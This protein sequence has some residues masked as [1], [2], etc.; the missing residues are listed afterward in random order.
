MVNLKIKLNHEL[1]KVPTKENFEDAGWDLYSVEDRVINTT[2]HELYHDTNEYGTPTFTR[3]IPFGST[4]IKT[5]IHIQ[6]PRGYVGLIWDR[7]GMAIKNN[8]HRVAGVIDSGY[9]G[10]IMVGLLNFGPAYKVKAGDKIAQ[11]LIQEVPLHVAWEIVEELDD[12]VRGEN[13]FGSSGK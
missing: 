5:G 3:F 4:V 9:T 7:S 11:L 10:E 12:S 13:G 6:I 1:A 8:I 2:P